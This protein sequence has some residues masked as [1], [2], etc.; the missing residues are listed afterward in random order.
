MNEVFSLT[1]PHGWTVRG[2]T[3]KLI[4]LKP[5]VEMGV[6]LKNRLT[7][8]TETW[9]YMATLKGE[10]VPYRIGELPAQIC[11]ATPPKETMLV[12]GW[13]PIFKG[14]DDRP[15]LGHAYW[16]RKDA[17]A[18]SRFDKP[19]FASLSIYRHVVEGEHVFIGDELDPR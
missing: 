8:H 13:C 9:T 4:E 7:V 2:E 18:N 10:T 16:S 6:P 3:V 12:V 17:E 11:N 15:R 14:D 1:W 5:P 19:Y